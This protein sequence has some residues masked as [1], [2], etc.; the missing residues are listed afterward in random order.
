MSEPQREPTV[1]SVSER[2]LIVD[3]VERS[4][5]EGS[6]GT[7]PFHDVRAFVA[8]RVDGELDDLVTVV[9]SLPVG[10]RVE[11]VRIDSEDGLS[12]L[13]HSAAHGLAQVVQQVRSD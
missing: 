3:G 7:D 13:L 6:A 10:S 4:V 12:I 11:P 8:V 5:T 2:V 9:S 1:P